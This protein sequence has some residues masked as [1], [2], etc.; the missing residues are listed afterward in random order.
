MKNIINIIFGAESKRVFLSVIIICLSS[1]VAMAQRNVSGIVLDEAGE[2]LIGATVKVDNSTTGTVSDLKGNFNIKVANDAKFI[3]VSYLGYKDKVVVLKSNQKSYKVNMELSEQTIK[4][5]VVIGYGAVK[6]GDVTAS[7]SKVDGKDLE[8]RPV[9]NVAQA[10]QGKLAGVEIR[11]G[12]QLGNDVNINVRGAVSLSDPTSTSTMDAMEKTEGDPADNTQPLFVVDGIPQSSDF[13]LGELNANDIASV[14]VLKDASSSAIYGSRGANGV[15]IV[16]TKRPTKNERTSISFNAS[17][18]IQQVEHYI[19]V[20]S[21]SK[22]SSWIDKIASARY[23]NAYGSVGGQSGDDYLM[24][25]IV[26]GATSVNDDNSQYFSD[27]RWKIQGH[28]GLNYVDWQKKM[29]RQAPQQSYSLSAS[30]SGNNSNLRMSLGYVNQQG[31]LRFSDYQRLGGTI[32]GEIKLGTRLTLGVNIAPS[33]SVRNGANVAGTSGESIS[34]GIVMSFLTYVPVMES[35]YGINT[36]TYPN[37]NYAWASNS[38]HNPYTRMEDTQRQTQLLTI[39]SSA[40]L[41][42]EIIKDFTAELTGSWNYRD[43][44]RRYFIPATAVMTPA[45]YTN[46]TISSEG[47]WRGTRSNGFMLQALLNYTHSFGKHSINLMAGWSA[48]ESKYSD[49][50]NIT[51]DGY[52]NETVKGFSDD[53][54]INTYI[55]YASYTTPDRLL[56]YFG[57]AIY[58]YNDR[59]IANVSLRRDGSSKLGRNNMWATFPAVSAAWR[60]S[61][62]S[63]YPKNAWVNSLKL[64]ASY[65]VNGNNN[66]RSNAA[67]ITLS[68]ANYYNGTTKLYGY[69]Q[70][71]AGNEDLTWNK[72]DSWDFAVDMGLFNNRISFA[73]DYYIKHTRNLLYSTYLPSVTG[74]ETIYNNIGKIDNSGLDFEFNSTNISG[75]FKWTTGIDFGI[76]GSKVKA[77]MGNQSRIMVGWSRTRN[78][79]LEVG[80]TVGEYY[81]YDAIGVFMTQSELDSYPHASGATVGSLKIRDANGD[82]N[83]TAEDRV[84]CG[85]P[86]AKFTFGVTNTFTW[87]SWMLSVLLTGQTGGKIFSAAGRTI[88]NS[89]N[90]SMIKANRLSDW[91]YS[92]TSTDA[93]NGVKPDVTGS[94]FYNNSTMWLYSSDYINIK[95][96]TLSYGLAMKKT[97]FVKNLTLLFSIENLKMFESYDSGYSPEEWRIKSSTASYDEGGY[98]SARTFSLGLKVT[99]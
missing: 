80:R 31:I 53:S 78:Q 45:D 79:V 24:R 4:D 89:T 29:F 81:L 56:S 93:G 27:P 68:N 94:S 54:V 98:P 69:V 6:K 11:S 61:N 39:R 59:Y 58:N 1:L 30:M 77:L 83:I 70:Q 50:Y 37:P 82:G 60:I 47:E 25:S 41:R 90:G 91:Y 75:Q 86:R 49:S 40:F 65:G 57:R 84:Y 32:S 46:G 63:F 74:F 99:L 28:P 19:D 43:N 87:K 48:S 14:E 42:Y 96:I 64:R 88:D 20:M 21:G 66:L 51:A 13:N 44:E 3:T 7:V 9:T 38:A 15:I 76:Q 23:A 18:S 92:W 35:E 52:S 55:N 73:V 36:G 72:V 97:F 5:V 2:G 33:F 12:G 22:W 67:K 34:D 62:E 10:L 26:T 95:N 71:N 85:S 8:D 17:F 16:T